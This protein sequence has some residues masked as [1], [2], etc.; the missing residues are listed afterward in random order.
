MIREQGAQTVD[1]Q[2]DAKR[3]DSSQHARTNRAL[4]GEALS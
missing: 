2:V 4:L 3:I 1:W